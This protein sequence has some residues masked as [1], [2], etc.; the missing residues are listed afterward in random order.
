MRSHY[1]RAPRHYTNKIIEALDEGML[2]RD[3]VIMAALSYMS[4]D[5]VKD[6]AHVNEFFPDEDDD[7]PDDDD[8][9]PDED[10]DEDDA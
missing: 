4:E 5:E 3:S 8:D 6:L 1:T 10:E 2:D 7:A 9:A